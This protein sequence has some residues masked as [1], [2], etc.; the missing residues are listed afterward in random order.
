MQVRDRPAQANSFEHV[1]S[2][3]SESNVTVG[4][5]VASSSMVYVPSVLMEALAAYGVQ[6]FT[7]DMRQ[8][9]PA[10]QCLPL[11]MGPWVSSPAVSLQLKT[12]ANLATQRSK[13]RAV[14]MAG[15]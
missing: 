1:Q 4:Y 10:L 12:D 13:G 15:C 14:N 7:A 2:L 9:V 3:T 6:K 8:F 5:Y 11:A